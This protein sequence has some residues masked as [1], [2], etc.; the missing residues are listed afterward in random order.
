MISLPEDRTYGLGGAATIDV[1]VANINRQNAAFQSTGLQTFDNAFHLYNVCET[2][3]GG[4]YV[5]SYV[6]RRLHAARHRRQ[7]HARFGQLSWQRSYIDT[8]GE[9]W[10]PFVFARLD[11]EGT[12]INESGSITYL[13]GY[14]T[15]TVANSSQ[16]RSSRARIAAPSPARWPAS[17]SNIASRSSRRHPG[18]RRR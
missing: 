7:L 3:V 13:S 10:K 12:A 11:G 16:R 18:G 6:P 4:K 2:I 17:G 14:G 5:N 8:L 15:S 1:N 9:V